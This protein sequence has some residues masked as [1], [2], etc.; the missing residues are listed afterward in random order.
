MAFLAVEYLSRKVYDVMNTKH[1]KRKNSSK[2][3]TKTIYYAGQWQGL[4]LND[5][6]NDKTS[7]ETLNNEVK[8][9][10]DQLK[11]RIKKEGFNIT[12]KAL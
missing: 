8:N 11:K 6:D 5:F 12:F 7:C 3:P 1:D 9:K 10:F 4:L 2:N